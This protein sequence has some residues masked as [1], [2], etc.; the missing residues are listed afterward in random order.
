MRFLVAVLSV[1]LTVASCASGPPVEPTPVSCEAAPQEPVRR[2]SAF[3]YTRALND[4]IGVQFDETLLPATSVTTIFATEQ[5]ALGSSPL[6][7]DGQFDASQAAA[8]AVVA[9]LEAG[10]GD[11]LVGCATSEP[12]CIDDFIDRFGK[13]PSNSRTTAPS[14]AQVRCRA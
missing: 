6:W 11:E 7:V 13:N 1:P 2:L 5:D 3:E 4:L 10:K 8:D 12:T 14:I 9:T